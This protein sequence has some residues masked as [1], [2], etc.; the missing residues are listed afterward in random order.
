MDYKTDV[1]DTVVWPRLF[2]YMDFT[3]DLRKRSTVLHEFNVDLTRITGAICYSFFVVKFIYS[4]RNYKLI[5]QEKGYMMKR[6]KRS[7]K[8]IKNDMVVR[9]YCMETKVDG[10]AKKVFHSVPYRNGR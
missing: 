6:E 3:L 4:N 10:N 1:G 8:Q 7:R 9:Y 5:F 2:F